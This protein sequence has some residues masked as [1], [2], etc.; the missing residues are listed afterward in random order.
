METTIPLYQDDD[1][2]VHARPET[3]K[4][5]DDAEEP[6]DIAVLATY[7]REI[8]RVPRLSRAE[9]L[10]LGERIAAGDAQAL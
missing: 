3:N 4:D 5:A 10:E 8:G 9:D 2:T 7:L 1:S 6:A